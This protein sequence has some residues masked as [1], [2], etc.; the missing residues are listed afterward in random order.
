M[1][2]KSSEEHSVA[3]LLLML[4]TLER[5]RAPSDDP[6][7]A[8]EEAKFSRSEPFK[9][10]R[11]KQIQTVEFPTTTIGSFPQTAGAQRCL[12]F[13]HGVTTG[14]ISP[15]PVQAA[16]L[17]GFSERQDGLLN[18][19]DGSCMTCGGRRLDTNTTLQ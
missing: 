1:L 3:L 5:V 10:R 4:Q 13:S 18:Q 9:T 6:K 12:C 15:T 14:I 11:A 2:G 17:P 7:E 8:I 19:P 16:S